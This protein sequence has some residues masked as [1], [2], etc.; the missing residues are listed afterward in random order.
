MADRELDGSTEGG[1]ADPA[2][3]LLAEGAAVVHGGEDDP[4]AGRVSAEED[5]DVDPI[6]I[7]ESLRE[8]RMAAISFSLGQAKHYQD[9]ADKDMKTVKFLDGQI[10]LYKAHRGG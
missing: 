4:V 9:I 7:M 5:P 10:D 1:N 3:G 6:L 8:E 2:S